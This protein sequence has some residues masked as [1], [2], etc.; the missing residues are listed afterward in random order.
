MTASLSQ[1][2]DAVNPMPTSLTLLGTAGRNKHGQSLVR[3]QCACGSPEFVCRADSFKSGNTTSCGCSRPGGRKH[4]RK[5]DPAPTSR[6]PPAAAPTSAPVEAER[7]TP[8]WFAEQIA[9]KEAAA[10]TLEKQANDLEEEMERV[11]IQSWEPGSEPPDKLWNRATTTAKKLR[12]EIARL[13][14]EK[15][16]AE[17]GTKKDTRTQAEITR[18]KIA[19]LR[20]SN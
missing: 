4:A 6:T 18:D 12:Q 15:D 10:L 17:T 11:G 7:G 8:A 20:G 13:M 14:T 9:T 1:L 3:V 19:A 16:N 5:P 2:P